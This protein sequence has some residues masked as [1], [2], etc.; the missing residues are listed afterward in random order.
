[1][2]A[3]VDAAATA[4]IAALASDTTVA[5]LVHAIGGEGERASPVPALWISERSAIPWG[6]KDRPGSEIRVELMCSDRSD[7]GR[8]SD[9]ASAVEAVIAGLPRDFAGWE[10]G[11]WLLLRRRAFRQRGGERRIGWQ[12]RLRGWPA[13]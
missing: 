2:T 11:E 3:L 6:S 8:S 9:I 10:V 4:L 13:N 7:G 5:D 12:L 1:M